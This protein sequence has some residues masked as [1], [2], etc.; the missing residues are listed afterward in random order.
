MTPE[1][2]KRIFEPFFTTKEVT[3]TGLGLWVSS[4][5]VAKHKGSIRVRSH[6]EK[7]G[8]RSGTIF[9]LFF[10]DEPKCRQPRTPRRQVMRSL[11]SVIDGSAF[12]AE[13]LRFCFE[14]VD[15]RSYSGRIEPV[16]KEVRFMASSGMASSLRIESGRCAK[17]SNCLSTSRRL[18]GALTHASASHAAGPSGWCARVDTADPSTRF[19]QAFR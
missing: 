10:P 2:R 9:E 16:L 1:V 19:R 3:G 11:P 5:I 14:C 4:E 6:S 18:A 7:L 17:K 13:I 8:G 15:A 12:E